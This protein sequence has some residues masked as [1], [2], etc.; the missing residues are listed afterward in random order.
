MVVVRLI[1]ILIVR[2][3]LFVVGVFFGETMKTGARG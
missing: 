1:L 2:I 3:W